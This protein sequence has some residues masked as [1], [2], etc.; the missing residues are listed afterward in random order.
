MEHCGCASLE[1][2]LQA[3]VPQLHHL[4]RTAVSWGVLAMQFYEFIECLVGSNPLPVALAQAYPAMLSLTST[5]LLLQ[6][7]FGVALGCYCVRFAF[8]PRRVVY[9]LWL[10]IVKPHCML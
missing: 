3:L 7:L 9:S 2:V 6:G 4:P 8:M 5:G 1:N 10:A